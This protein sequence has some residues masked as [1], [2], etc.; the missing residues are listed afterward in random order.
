MG[1]GFSTRLR[2]YVTKM[3]WREETF[4]NELYEL[5]EFTVLQTTDYTEDT[6]DLLYNELYEL[7][8]SHCA[9]NHGL[10]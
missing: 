8:E 4:H 7:D 2:P 1:Q 9:L 10:H 6:D 3:P 5:Y